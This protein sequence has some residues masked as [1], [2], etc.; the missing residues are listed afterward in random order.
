MR[1]TYTQRYRK[2]QEGAAVGD[3]HTH[4][5]IHTGPDGQVTE[6]THSHP[7][8]GSSHSHDGHHSHTHTHTNTK[9]V[10]N[11]LSRAIGH[12]ESIKRMVED[13]RDCSEVLIQLSAVKS[14]I[15]NTG[16]VILQDHIEHCIVD[17]V[18]SG[19][20]EALE[21]LSRAIDR[22]IK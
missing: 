10:L 21:E 9:A 14:A 6:H 8:D 11:R 18:E 17:A 13:G 12:L 16:K 20:H 4:T 3:N 22:F 1:K 5:H 2:K 19:D 15:N 7:S